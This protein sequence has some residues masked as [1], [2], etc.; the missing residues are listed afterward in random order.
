MKKTVNN[1]H[2]NKN[3]FFFGYLFT[4][5]C[6]SESYVKLLISTKYLEK[7]KREV[8]EEIL[9]KE[10][11]NYLRFNDH[12]GD[13]HARA[14][15]S[16]TDHLINVYCVHLFTVGSGSVIINL[17][18]PTLDSLEHLWSDY[19]AGHLDILAERY[20]VTDDIKKKLNLET[21]CL[22]TTIE[23][24]DYLNCKK[25]LMELRST[26]SGEFKQNV[27]EVQLCTCRCSSLVFLFKAYMTPNFFFYL[28]RKSFQ[29]DE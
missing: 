29:N 8:I 26:Y 27:W 16:F 6:S 25:A 3:L 14:M 23:E 5:L 4:Y 22:K 24:E 21:I 20:L 17:D 2:L 9:A 13:T 19:L 1:H 15:K 7:E 11:Q 28:I 18:C 12:S 10:V